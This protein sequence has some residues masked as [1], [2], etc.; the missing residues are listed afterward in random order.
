MTNPL[1]AT[2]HAARGTGQ[3]GSPT[4]EALAQ[5]LLRASVFATGASAADGAAIASAGFPRPT[6]ER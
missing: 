4:W 5:I 1:L 3:I 6:P 2:T